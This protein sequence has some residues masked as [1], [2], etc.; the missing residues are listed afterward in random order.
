[1]GVPPAIP[2]T[3]AAVAV[4]SVSQSEERSSAS[5]VSFPSP[6][7]PPVPTS[8]AMGA[9]RNSRKMDAS[10]AATTLAAR[11]G[12]R[13]RV[14]G[15]KGSKGSRVGVEGGA[16]GNLG[17]VSSYRDRC[18]QPFYPFDPVDPLPYIPN[19]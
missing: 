9:T 2:Q 6:L 7:A 19:P 18:Y 15:V 14:E 12:S 1:M 4:T 16:R 10:V 5:V 11:W 17:N 3:T 8:S 13:E